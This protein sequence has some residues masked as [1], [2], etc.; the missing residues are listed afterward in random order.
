MGEGNGFVPLVPL[1]ELPDDL[2]A[3]WEVTPRAGL[4]DFLRLMANAPDFFR[5]FSDLN[6]KIRAN[7]HLGPRTTELVRLAVAQTTRC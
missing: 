4:Q 2:R 1:E 6:G 3:Q 7:N 5:G